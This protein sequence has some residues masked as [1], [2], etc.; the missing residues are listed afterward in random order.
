M[1]LAK[2]PSLVPSTYLCWLTTSASW[3]PKSFSRGQRHSQA[4]VYVGAQ[5]HAHTLAHT[6]TYTHTKI[7]FKKILNV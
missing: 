6:H 3:D 1:A 7:I 5:A 4:Q 2:D